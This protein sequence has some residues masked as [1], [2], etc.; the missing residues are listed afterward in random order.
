MI[1]RNSR[2]AAMSAIVALVWTIGCDDRVVEV[3]REAADRQAAQNEQMGDLQKEVAHG[4]RSLVEA[5]AAARQVI[6]DVHRDLQAERRQLGTSWNDLEAQRQQ[7]ARQR[8]IESVLVPLLTAM[9]GVVLVVVLLSFLR[10]LLASSHTT[11]SIDA[12]L[13]NLLVEQ[14]LAI[15]VR[16]NDVTGQGSEARVPIAPPE[17][18]ATS[19]NPSNLDS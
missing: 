9:S 7:V 4:T 16:S 6:V 8:H 10:Q 18:T 13:Q 12:E 2:C 1:L 19:S 3:A 14:V 11:Q 5:D 15:E 17:S